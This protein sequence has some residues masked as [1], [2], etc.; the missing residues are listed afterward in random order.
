MAKMILIVCDVCGNREKETTNYRIVSGGRT[1]E[2]DL[3]ADDAAPVEKF[4][5]GTRSR[6]AGRRG[7]TGTR[8]NA[9]VATPEQIESQK[10]SGAK[11]LAGA[12]A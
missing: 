9:R 11:E 12:S 2:L 1:K 8:G 10:R 7:G 3:C 5:E 4:L 6:T